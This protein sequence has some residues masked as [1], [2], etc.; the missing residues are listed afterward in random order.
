MNKKTLTIASIVCIVLIVIALVIIF[1][2]SGVDDG[3]DYDE[4]SVEKMLGTWKIT[5]QS[6]VPTEHELIY[7]FY[8]NMTYLIE[9]DY[10]GFEH[11]YT[12]DFYSSSLN[13]YI[14]NDKIKLFF[15]NYDSSA[16]FE[17]RGK[18]SNNG[19]TLKLYWIESELFDVIMVKQ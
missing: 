11:N 4:L 17:Y 5:S 7:T 14:E 2:I 13:Y 15:S 6:G 12:S 10:S 8:D 1:L 18:F 19:N 16:Y 3:K 9:A